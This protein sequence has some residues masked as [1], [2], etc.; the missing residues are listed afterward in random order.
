MSTPPTSIP[1]EE[2]EQELAGAFVQLA[3]TL[4]DDYDVTELLHQLS[5]NCVRLLP[6]DAA[7]LLLSDQR[8]ALQV[9]AASTEDI[10]LL[11]L[12]QLQAQEGP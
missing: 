3:D 8:G 11:E 2:P 4:V 9:V 7:G 10:Q 6:V 1:P 5:A 12:F